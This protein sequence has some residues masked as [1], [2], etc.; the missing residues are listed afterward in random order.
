MAVPI[1]CLIDRTKIAT[2]A[3][4][5]SLTSYP[6][7]M[8]IKYYTEPLET[9]PQS[10]LLPFLLFSIVGVLIL[11]ALFSLIPIGSTSK[12]SEPNYKRWALIVGGVLAAVLALSVTLIFWYAPSAIGLRKPSPWM[13][14][15]GYNVFILLSALLL[16]L[17]S[18]K[19]SVNR[20][21]LMRKIISIGIVFIIGQYTFVLSL[22]LLYAFPGTPEKSYPVEASCIFFANI[23]WATLLLLMNKETEI[24]TR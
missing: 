20:P 2:S 5:L 4:I 9:L 1:L 11:I 23:T 21:N 6:L 18:Q 12:I 15:V 10:A 3:G 16:Y 24:S 19:N 8:G 17:A 22:I 7:L 13:G 14:V